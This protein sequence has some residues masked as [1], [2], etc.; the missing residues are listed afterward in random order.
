[1][2]LFL[3]GNQGLLNLPVALAVVSDYGGTVEDA[4]TDGN[5]LRA[6]LRALPPVSHLE[7]GGGEPSAFQP[8][9]RHV[10]SDHPSGRANNES[11]REHG[12]TNLNRRF[13]AAVLAFLNLVASQEDIPGRSFLLP[14]GRGWPM[15]SEADFVVVSARAEA[16]YFQTIVGLANA[17][18]EAQLTGYNVSS[19][20][21]SGADAKRYVAFLQGSNQPNKRELGISRFKCFPCRAVARWSTATRIWTRRSATASNRLT[22]TTRSLSTRNPPSL[23]TNITLCG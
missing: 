8:Q 11:A 16:S 19:P 20:Q 6:Q 23:L 1:M 2:E 7:Q 15:L 4:S 18:R 12:R 9:G 22:R 10:G 21:L 13:T 17:L 14:L 5:V 3:A